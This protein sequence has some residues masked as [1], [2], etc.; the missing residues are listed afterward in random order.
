MHAKIGGAASKQNGVVRHIARVADDC[1]YVCVCVLGQIYS[2]CLQ[3]ATQAC[4][5][6]CLATTYRH[7]RQVATCL[8]LDVPF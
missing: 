3:Q 2:R 6:F 8:L 4:E 1:G 5:F 7:S